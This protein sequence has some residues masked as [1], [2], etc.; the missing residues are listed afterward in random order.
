MTDISFYEYFKK[1]EVATGILKQQAG[2][3]DYEQ[4]VDSYNDNKFVAVYIDV[5]YALAINS[6]KIRGQL[7]EAAELFKAVGGEVYALSSKPSSYFDD[8]HYDVFTNVY[9]GS[10]VTK[11]DK[12]DYDI[13]VFGE[14][15]FC[16]ELDKKAGDHKNVI[17]DVTGTTFLS[18]Y[19]GH[20]HAIN[21]TLVEH[22]LFFL[23]TKKYLK[24][25]ELNTRF[26]KMKKFLKKEE[27]RRNN[28]LKKQMILQM[29]QIK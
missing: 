14:S 11:E 4:I 22:L 27:E 9:C 3:I 19:Y 18:L 17:V 10:D 24:N 6:T 5:D 1:L 25:L 28:K 8:G 20:S 29:I 12:M 15:I 21:Y 23:A 7:Y 13:Y 26:D 16:G 2:L